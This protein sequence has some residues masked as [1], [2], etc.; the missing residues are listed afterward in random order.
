M[1]EPLAPGPVRAH[2]VVI[3][4]VD[5]ARVRID[6]RKAPS[7]SAA[8]PDH[9]DAALAR[10][11]AFR[12]QDPTLERWRAAGLVAAG[13]VSELELDRSTPPLAPAPAPRAPAPVL[14]RLDL[15]AATSGGEPWW[16]AESGAD[17]TLKA[18]VF[19]AI[20]ALYG[21][22]TSRDANGLRDQR[23][24]L[25]AGAGAALPLTSAGLELRLRAELTASEVR[26]SI[27]QAATAR[28]DAGARALIGAA[29]AIEVVV[30]LG[31]SLAISGGARLDELGGRTTVRVQSDPAGTIPAWLPSVALGVDVRLP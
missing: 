30:P 1:D 3:F 24:G 15:G 26:A 25:A 9:D 22:T 19:V 7:A 13:L 8:S 29:A 28:E 16:V 11:F 12:E 18:P 5:G 17:F 31:R 4:A 21:Q 6:A 2:V 14:V 20:A 10:E 23:A 27:R